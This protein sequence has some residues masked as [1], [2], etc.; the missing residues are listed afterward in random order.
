MKKISPAVAIFLV[1]TISFVQAQQPTLKGNVSDTASKQNLEHALISLL[2]AK[3]STL[4]KFTRA[5]K[6]GNFGIANLVKGAY[7]MVI[8]YPG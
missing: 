3:D 7:K 1:I 2:R 8:T 5:D 4:Y 6:Q